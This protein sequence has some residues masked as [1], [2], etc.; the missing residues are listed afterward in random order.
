DGSTKNFRKGRDFKK[1]ELKSI[2]LTIRPGPAGMQLL[3]DP[4]GKPIP[5]VW[6]LADTEYPLLGRRLSKEAPSSPAWLGISAFVDP[7]VGVDYKFNRQSQILT[8]EHW[9]DARMS[10]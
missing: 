6:I 4:D 1:E 7:R 5:E 3:T 9:P 10:E 8:I 2:H